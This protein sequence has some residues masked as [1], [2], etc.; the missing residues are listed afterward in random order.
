MF[1]TLTHFLSLETHLPALAGDMA[2]A[3]LAGLCLLIP[4]AGYAVYAVKVLP[5]GH[6]SPVAQA[7]YG[8]TA[9]AATMLLQPVTLASG[10]ALANV[11]WR[12]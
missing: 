11:V 10:V 5:D 6:R 12:L 9:L 3:T 7:I 2:V 1:A 4:L 8:F